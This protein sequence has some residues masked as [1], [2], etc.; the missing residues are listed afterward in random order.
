MMTRVSRQG[1]L[2]AVSPIMF[3]PQDITN[4]GYSTPHTPENLD[5]GHLERP[6]NLP[7]SEQRLAFRYFKRAGRVLRFHIL[8][9]YIRN[10][11][12]GGSGARPWVRA[13]LLKLRF[14]EVQEY[15]CIIPTLT[16]FLIFSFSY[17]LSSLWLPFVLHIT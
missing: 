14:I 6:I 17:I 9:R 12:A 13:H 8:Y 4:V 7:H 2:G 16:P 1:L 3:I 11:L 10:E 5:M 15:I